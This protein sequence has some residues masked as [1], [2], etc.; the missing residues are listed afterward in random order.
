MDQVFTDNSFRRHR[1]AELAYLMM[2]PFII[3][4]ILM[5][6]NKGTNI[7]GVLLLIS[8]AIIAAVVGGV[9]RVRY[10]LIKIVKLNSHC[11]I[12]FLN[13]SKRHLINCKIEEITFL[14]K[15]D[16]WRKYGKS[17]VIDVLHNNKKLLT[18]NRLGFIK[19][20]RWTV[21]VADSLFKSGFIVKYAQAI[22]V[23]KD[24]GESQEKLTKKS[25]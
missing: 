13:Y 7:L 11:E 15:R 25:G 2:F 20:T 1:Y 9:Q 6:M 16:G 12:T 8:P 19:P 3:F 17:Y 10:A 4:V 14:V 5:I 23:T 18:I 22:S 24:W 21:Q